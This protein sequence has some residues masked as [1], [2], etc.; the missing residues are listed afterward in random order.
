VELVTSR[1]ARAHGEQLVHTP[2]RA[3]LHDELPSESSA[4]LILRH[5]ESNPKTEAAPQLSETESRLERIRHI[6]DAHA[7]VDQLREQAIASVDKISRTVVRN[8]GFAWLERGE[9]GWSG[10]QNAW[11]LVRDMAPAERDR[12][13]RLLNCLAKGM[14]QSGGTRSDRGNELID[15]AAD[16]EGVLSDFD[17]WCRRLRELQPEELD[18]A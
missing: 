12:F 10:T 16:L 11:R 14:Q 1:N 5:A 13:F 17:F 7:R 15:L 18:A 6:A 8:S 9:F 3:S 2:V 4:P